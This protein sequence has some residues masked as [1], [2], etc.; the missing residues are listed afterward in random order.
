VTDILAFLV[1]HGEVV[2]F[3][4]VFADQLGVPLPAVPI[5]L[6]AGGLAG[7]GRLSFPVAVGLAVAPP[8]AGVVGVGVFQF[9][10]YSAA[11]AFLW[12]G[13]WMALGYAAGSALE[14]VSAHAEQVGKAFAVALAAVIAAYVVF[15][16]IQRQRLLRSLRIARGDCFNRESAVSDVLSNPL[17]VSAQAEPAHRRDRLHRPLASLTDRFCIGACE[18]EVERATEVVDAFPRHGLHEQILVRVEPTHGLWMPV[19][20]LAMQPDERGRTSLALR[21]ASRARRRHLMAARRLDVL[22]AVARSLYILVA[23]RLHFLA[24]W[25]LDVLNRRGVRGGGHQ[26]GC[27]SESDCVRELHVFFLLCRLCPTARLQSSGHAKRK[28]NEIIENGARSEPGAGSKPKP[29]VHDETAR[30]VAVTCRSA[31]P[32]WNAVSKWNAGVSVFRDS[33]RARAWHAICHSA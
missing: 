21:P 7:A 29:R 11:S 1:R 33:T 17:L 18:S 31:V 6:A 12:A 14:R 24:A 4:Y 27:Q 30:A 22:I 10:I 19:V 23:R 32:H 26:H 20:R 25:R 15:K 3:L 13:A 16:W 5:L 8:L 28:P 2:L 9:L